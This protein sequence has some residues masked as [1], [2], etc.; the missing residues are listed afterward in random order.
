MCPPIGLNLVPRVPHYSRALVVC[1]AE[2]AKRPK[3]DVNTFVAELPFAL[4][5]APT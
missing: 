1:V 2:E 5:G 4:V 3:E